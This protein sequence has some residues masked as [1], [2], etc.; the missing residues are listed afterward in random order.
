MKCIFIYNPKSGRGKILKKLD[1]IVKTLYKKFDVVDVYESQ[2]AND[3][4]AKVKESCLI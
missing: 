4:M 3:V 2:S 1:Y